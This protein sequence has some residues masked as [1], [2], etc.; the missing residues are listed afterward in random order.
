MTTFQICEKV[1]QMLWMKIEAA[2][3]KLDCEHVT[4]VHLDSSILKWMTLF[5][6]LFSQLFNV[7]M[8]YSLF[9]TLG[10]EDIS[11]QQWDRVKQLTSLSF[12]SSVPGYGHKNRNFWIMPRKK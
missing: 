7:N 3:T 11:S 4:L 2:P 9:V 1:S 8:H 6:Q 10:I 12:V 5:P